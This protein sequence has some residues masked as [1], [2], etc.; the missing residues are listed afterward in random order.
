MLDPLKQTGEVSYI[1]G[2]CTKRGR[3]SPPFYKEGDLIDSEDAKEIFKPL[4]EE[5][6]QKALEYAEEG[7]IDNAE[8]EIGD[9]IMYHFMVEGEAPPKE[10]IE[11]IRSK[12]P[13]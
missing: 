6:K 5:S 11:E 7:D 13:K 4:L 10:M 12:Y 8:S 2:G 9:V 3:K 1:F